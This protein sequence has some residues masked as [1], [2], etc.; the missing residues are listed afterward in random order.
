ML[1]E[2]SWAGGFAVGFV[3]VIAAMTLYLAS[4]HQQL[5]LSALPRRVLAVTGVLALILALILI[6]QFTG[7]AT[8]V[9]ILLTGLSLLWTLVPP[10]LSY[11]RAVREEPRH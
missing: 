8:S 1:D 9:F 11:I 3:V 2:I 6:N 10:L 7:S 4:P 5:V